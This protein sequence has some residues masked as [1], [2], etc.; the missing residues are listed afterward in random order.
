MTSTVDHTDELRARMAGTVVVPADDDFD[1][2]RRVW[3]GGIDRRPAVVA[4]CAGTDDV[5]AAVAYARA[6]DLEISVCC[7]AHNTAG[8]GVGEAGLMI[9]LRAMNSVEVDPTTRRAVV[10]GGA[11]LRDVDAAT[12]QFG[13]A[14]PT[15]EI[16]HTG[17][18]GLALGGGLGWLTRQCG[19]TS[20]N[21]VAAEVVLADGRVVRASAEENP[22]LFW[23]LRGGGGNFGVVTRFELALHPVGPMIRF[24]LLFRGLDDAG[25]TLRAARDVIPSLPD[26]VSFEVVAVNAPP[27][28]FVPEEM[29]LRPG[30]ALM[31]VGYGSEAEHEEVL[32]RLR[33]AAPPLFEFVTPMPYTD[34]Q[35]MFDEA[36]AWG[37][38]AYEKSC[39]L[40]E[41][42]DPVIDVVD[43]LVQL[44]TS[45]MS[46]LF[47]YTL[48]GAY[49]APDDAATA[50]SGGRSPRLGV[51]IIGV[52]PDAAGADAERGWVRGVHAALQ[53]HALSTGAYVNALDHDDGDRIRA[54]YGDK[55]D[56]LAAIKAVY[57]PDNVF[58]RNLNI[59]PVPVPVTDRL[60]AR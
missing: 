5:V 46:A 33:A 8:L 59:P 26:S 48:S 27:A 36:M 57:D 22:D 38:H 14:V 20:D 60:A 24:G 39:Y 7:G 3:N 11:L 23:A 32:D 50:F 16:G 15:G 40:A 43:E 58:H 51:F 30:Y 6:H 4:R 10:G 29:H 49:C 25:T 54:S 42:T 41:L 9:D 21:L 2:A 28:P 1:E 19:T 55:Y 18:G 53:P 12:Q 56:R 17:I 13:L 37:V 31:A 47:F 44:K 35:Q 34:L 45:P 52:T